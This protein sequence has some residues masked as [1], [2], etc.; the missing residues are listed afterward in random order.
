MRLSVEQ[1]LSVTKGRLAAGSAEL[2]VTAVSTDSRTLA[3]GSCFVAI[4][5]ERFD[6]HAFLQQAADK[7]ATALLVSGGAAA[8]NLIEYAG[9]VVIVA[10]TLRALGDLAAWHRRRLTCRVVAVTGSC[11]KSSVK[12][13][14]GQVLAS[15]L[16]GRRAAASFNNFVGVPL[17]ILGAEPDDEYLVVELGT[18]A[19]GEIRRLAEI[20]SPDIAVVTCVGPVHLEGLGS[21]EGVASEKE[22]LIRAL[23]SDGVAILNA[24]DAH[25]AAMAEAATTVR[26]FG[27]GDGD[28]L[29]SD[30]R[31]EARGV[32]FRLDSGVEI[33]LP[34]PGRHNVTNA[35]AAVAVAREF[36]FDDEQIAAALAQYRP[37]AMRLARE[38]LPG[39]VTLI[40][41]CYNANPISSMAAL[42]VL[43]EHP[44]RGRRVLV[45]GDM[46]ELGPGSEAFHADLGRAVAS[47]SVRMLVTVGSETRRT[48]MA[49]SERSDL[50]RFHFPDAR[51]AAGEVPG[52]LEAADVV[53]VKGSSRIDLK[54]VSEAIRKAFGAGPESADAPSA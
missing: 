45:Q 33:R 3:A 5:G 25:V 46:L 24:D 40:D 28:V 53:L 18:N 43:C 21:V 34:V 39:G 9:A 17:T 42:G 7:G 47:S 52:L 44:A 20:A 41:D 23:G 16:H 29:A 26:T 27:I 37:L 1:I 13:M 54:Q 14:T 49:A 48:S 15:R 10:D 12:E 8:S 30:V 19:P 31:T 22:E 50:M 2:Q 51:T 38:E 6:G 4:V 35:L 36:G 11:G 32:T